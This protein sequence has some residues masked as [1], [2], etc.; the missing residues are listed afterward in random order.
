MSLTTYTS[1]EL[2]KE[3]YR[4]EAMEANAVSDE[5]AR[6]LAAEANEPIPEV[7]LEELPPSGPAAPVP[8]VK[9]WDVICS[10]CKQPAKVGF[11]PDNTRPVFCLKCYKQR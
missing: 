9:T 11:K 10:V 3:L 8:G 7:P 2:I 4:R 1:I 6:E 5:K